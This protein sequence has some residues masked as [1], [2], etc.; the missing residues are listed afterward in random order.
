MSEFNL[1]V[2][3]GPLLQIAMVA[4]DD[5]TLLDLIGPH[6]V[7]SNTATIHVV[8]PTLAP[9]ISD[10]GLA[11]LPTCTYADCPTELDVLFVP[12]GRGSLNAMQDTALLDFLRDRAKTSRYVT[13]VCSGALV[14]GAAGL[15]E[16]RK[17]TTHWAT[18]EVLGA[19]A[20]VEPVRERVVIDGDRMTGG[21]VTA[22]IDFG[23][24][25]LAALRG[26]DVAKLT[27]LLMEYN[28]APP[29]D[30]GSPEGAGEVIAQMGRG[31]MGGFAE[32]SMQAARRSPA[33]A[34][35]R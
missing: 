22:G 24:T 13:S 8:S 2:P 35:S 14:L 30:A 4:F 16:G 17:A 32:A 9:V 10:S 3:G 6:A 15:L 29:F 20:D 21:G 23:L 27:Q 31:L 25:L 11:I 19:F 33:A 34:R 28:P 12:G 5:L 7:F 18:H 26:E 1:D